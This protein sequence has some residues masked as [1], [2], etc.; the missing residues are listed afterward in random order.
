M[1]VLKTEHKH[2]GSNLNKRSCCNKATASDLPFYDIFAP[3]KFLFWKFLMTSLHVICGLGLSQSKI[4]AT[5]M[6]QCP[7]L[8][9][10]LAVNTNFLSLGLIQSGIE[11]ESTVSGKDTRPLISKRSLFT[12]FSEYVCFHWCCNWWRSSWKIIRL[13]FRCLSENFRKFPSTLHGWK[14]NVAQWINDALSSHSNT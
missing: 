14:R 13:I 5:P 7:S 6:A 8:N 10:P 4:L 11:P 1:D 12:C 9:T 3:Q 2:L